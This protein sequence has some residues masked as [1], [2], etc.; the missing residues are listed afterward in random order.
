V[1]P[2]SAHE[3]VEILHRRYPPESAQAWDR[4]GVEF[5]DLSRAAKKIYF[6]VDVLP[7]TVDEA[8]AWGADF[9]IAHHPLFLFEFEEP[10]PGEEPKSI[11]PWKSC[12]AERLRSAGVTLLIAHTNADIASPGVNDA[13][14]EAIGLVNVAPL[15][16]GLGRIGEVVRPVPLDKFVEQISRNLPVG[17]N[18]VRATGAPN[19]LIKR[20]ALCGGSGDDRIEIAQGL[21]V[22]AYLTS[23]LKHHRVNE[24]LAAGAPVL[25]DAGHFA[26]EWPWLSQAA[27]LLAEDLEQDGYAR[28]E[29]KISEISTDPWRVR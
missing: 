8:I 4:V 3:I 17:A 13:L 7:E 24:A 21:G 29:M 26:T 2:A 27:Q 5:G 16:E 23:D 1:K 14:A 9:F 19:Q 25:I 18:G 20:V 15:P 12:L 6:A 22:D 28:P 10:L 11:A